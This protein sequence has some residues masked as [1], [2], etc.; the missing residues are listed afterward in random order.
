MAKNHIPTETLRNENVPKTY[1]AAL[2]SSS[3]Q[4]YVKTGPKNLSPSR[5]GV[6]ILLIVPWRAGQY[7]RRLIG[8]C[9][10]GDRFVN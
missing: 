5:L 3:I 2:K 4:Y 1:N 6:Q 9:Y 8:G 7:D 10:N